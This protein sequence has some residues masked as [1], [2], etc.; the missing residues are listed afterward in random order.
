MYVFISVVYWFCRRFDVDV[1]KS[2]IYVDKWF[3]EIIVRS[4]LFSK[5]GF[6]NPD[7]VGVSVVIPLDDGLFVLGFTFTDVQSL[8]AERSQEIGVLALEFLV[9]AW[10]ELPE[11]VMLLVRLA[12]MDVGSIVL[13]A[14]RDLDSQIV[15]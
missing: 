9:S 10:H 2:F 12:A 3:K 11:F 5:D 13:A 14:A 4:D 15:G 7:L 6:D 1:R 8:S